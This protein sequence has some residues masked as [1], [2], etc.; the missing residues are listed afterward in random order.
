MRIPTID[1]KTLIIFDVIFFSI[2]TGITLI[3]GIKDLK[4]SFK[5][6]KEQQDEQEKRKAPDEPEFKN[7]EPRLDH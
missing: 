2:I 5:K 1:N 3:L 6:L 7:R 4:V